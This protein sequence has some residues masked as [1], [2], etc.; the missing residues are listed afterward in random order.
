[1]IA[2]LLVV[3]VG[4]V[5]LILGIRHKTPKHPTVAAPP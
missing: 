5:L 3:V 1:V 2:A 4:I